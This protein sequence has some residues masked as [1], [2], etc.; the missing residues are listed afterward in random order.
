MVA[1]HQERL[2]QPHLLLLFL[3]LLFLLDLDAAQCDK[4]RGNTRVRGYTHRMV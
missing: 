2:R 1:P 3:L 4:A